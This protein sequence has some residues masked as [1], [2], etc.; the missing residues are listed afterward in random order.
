MKPVTTLLCIFIFFGCENSFTPEY[1]LAWEPPV[2]T[3]FVAYHESGYTDYN[4]KVWNYR[5]P[6]TT[7]NFSEIK[8]LY[9]SSN[10]SY[11]FQ[12]N[13]SV[14]PTKTINFQIPKTSRVT[15]SFLPARI[16]SE[17]I[18]SVAQRYANS[19]T[20]KLHNKGVVM[21][22]KKFNRGN[23]TVPLDMSKL[24]TGFYIVILEAGD[25]KKQTQFYL[26][27]SC[28]ESYPELRQFVPECQVQ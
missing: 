8:N 5:A 27:N 3:S 1:P 23:H 6:V 9:I 12:K 20:I 17:S 13:K 22:D 10:S 25:Y 11:N 7:I 19:Q 4:F 15:I 28:N 21:V 26:V 18:E 2:I 24:V 14:R 16:P